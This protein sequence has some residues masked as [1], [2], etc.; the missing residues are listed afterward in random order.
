MVRRQEIQERPAT[1]ADDRKH[2]QGLGV[3][4]HPVSH[5]GPPTPGRI[6]AMAQS[7]KGTTSA[8]KRVDPLR[9]QTG[10][11]RVEIINRMRTKAAQRVP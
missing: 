2:E 6:A 7:Y 4:E 8:N 3:T 11:T 5:P 9:S 1:Q 10:L